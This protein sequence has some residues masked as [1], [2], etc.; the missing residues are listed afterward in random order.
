MLLSELNQI[1]YGQIN[2]VSLAVARRSNN[3][4]AHT[5]NLRYLNSMCLVILEQDRIMSSTNQPLGRR[6]GVE[7]GM[8]NLSGNGKIPY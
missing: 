2:M 5:H 1:M 3:A 6:N 4:Y 8:V 7:N